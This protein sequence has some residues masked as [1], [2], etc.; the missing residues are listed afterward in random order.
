VALIDK[1][2]AAIDTNNFGLLDFELT[3]FI[4]RISIR[5]NSYCFFP[6]NGL[7]G[8]A[9]MVPMLALVAFLASCIQATYCK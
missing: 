9:E 7:A 3:E 2:K 5:I 8:R 1:T 6:K 4:C